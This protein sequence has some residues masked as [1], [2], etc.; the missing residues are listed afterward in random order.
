MAGVT[1]NKAMTEQ[2]T[3]K[4]LQQE[5]LQAAVT[6]K[7]AL[8]MTVHVHQCVDSTN[9]W[10]LQQCRSGRE[11]PFAC[12]AEQQTA[13]RGRRGKQWL[14]PAYSNIA[15]SVSWPF[16]LSEQLNLLPLSIALAIVKTLETFNLEQVQIKWPNDV[17]V[18]GR[19]IAGILIETQMCN[20][21][22]SAE[23]S[24]EKHMAV[25]IGVGLNYDMSVLKTEERAQM[26]ALTDICAELESQCIKCKP[27]RNAV[28][29]MLLQH[30]VDTCAGFEQGAGRHLQEFRS[31]Y[32][33]CKGKNVEI[34]Q[35]ADEVLTGVAVGVSDD[36]ELLVSIDGELRAFNSAEVSVRAES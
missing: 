3:L 4:Q 22:Q 26:P 13:G 20:T 36:A 21:M 9:S 5:F 30:M 33:F 28:A 11:M 2:V 31:R 8:D 7:N 34:K 27:G 12:F 15:M 14:M 35:D 16:V 32:D 29:S 10:C 6:V 1:I 17:Y 19:K 18:R 25:V 23:N 24:N